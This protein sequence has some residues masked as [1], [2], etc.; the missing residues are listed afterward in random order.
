VP[1]GRNEQGWRPD[2]Q[3]AGTPVGGSNY[4]HAPLR[5]CD[6]RAGDDTAGKQRRPLH[7][8]EVA[9]SQGYRRLDVRR[10]HVWFPCVT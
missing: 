9:H 4:R 8:G 2:E 7:G 10:N 6:T 1:A 3:A 5:Y